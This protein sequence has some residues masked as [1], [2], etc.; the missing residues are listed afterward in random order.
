MGHSTGCA[1]LLAAAERLPPGS[2]EK[3][4]LL[5]PSVPDQYD[6]RPALIT[7]RKGIDSFYSPQ[8][9]L[10][11][12]LGMMIIGTTDPNSRTAAGLSGFRQIYSGPND[13]ALYQKLTQH[14]WDSSM[15][16]SG[17]DGSHCGSATISAMPTNA[18]T[19]D[20][21][22]SLARR[23]KLI[24]NPSSIVVATAL[25]PDRRWPAPDPR[26]RSH[27]AG[28]GYSASARRSC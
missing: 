21:I 19:L 28:C 22:H 4:T 11:L 3:I 20:A 16:S 8:D 25:G 26:P 10:V 27:T 6:L 13:A 7:S 23:V 12:G 5:A 18:N 17:N 9:Q 1:V 14:P 2:I 24:Q 15:E